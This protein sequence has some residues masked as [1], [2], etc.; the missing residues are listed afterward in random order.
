VKKIYY[1]HSKLIYNTEREEMERKAIN[2]LAGKVLCPN[3]DM[4]E[5][6]MMDPYIE[7]VKNSKAV[8]CSE[9]NRHVGRGVYFEVFTA[10]NDGK[11]V[12]CLRIKSKT[13]S[14]YKVLGIKV[15][16]EDDWKMRYAKLVISRKS[17]SNIK[18]KMA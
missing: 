11:P 4:G 15:V 10:I 2:S 13:P 1:A 6:G 9:Y 3:R 5:Y 14:F 12:F 7:A 18:E 17:E 8:V 16:D